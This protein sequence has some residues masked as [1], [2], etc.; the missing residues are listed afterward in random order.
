MSP[1][2]MVY[3]Y[4]NEAAKLNT[5]IELFSIV[6]DL[7]Q[8]GAKPIRMQVSYERFMSE[9]HSPYFVLSYGQDAKF[10]SD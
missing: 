9:S 4:S 1:F 5:K 3:V 6:D 7:I 10:Y 2:P 8:T